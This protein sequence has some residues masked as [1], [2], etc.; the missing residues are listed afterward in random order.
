MGVM[1]WIGILAAVGLGGAGQPTTPAA[2]FRLQDHRGA[3]HTLDEARDRKVVVLAFLGTECP[4]AE[5]Y[6]PRLAGVARDFEARG[7]AFFGIDANPQDGPV[8]IGRFAEKHGLPFPILKDTGGELA[9]R[10]GAERTPEVF[11]LD[12]SRSVAY[13]GRIDDQYAIGVHRPSPTRNDLIDALDALL[14]G[15]PVAAPR[16]EAPGCKIGRAAKPAEDAGVTYAKQVSRILQSHCV[17]CHRPGEI[18]PFSLMDYRQAAGWSSMI[19]EVVDEGRMPPWHASPEHGTFANDARLSADEKKAIREW[20]AAGAPEGNPADLPP[21]PRFVEGWQIPRPDLVLEMPRE[22]EIPAEGSMPYQVVELDPKLT[23]DVWVRASQVRPGNPS[24]V[25]HVVV[26]VLPP[27]VEKIDEA[28]GDFLAAYAPGMPPRILADGVAKRIP[29]G[30]RIALQLHYTPRGTKQVDRSRIG[31][32]FADPA[33]VR[34]EL[35][36]GMALDVRLQIP[37]GTR[38]Y[39]SRAEFRFSRPS[40][41]LSLL[42]HMHLRGRSMTFVAEYP[43]GRREVLLD[44]PR[45][46]FDWQ[47]LYVLDRPKPM[48]EGTIL[49]TEAHFD[50]SAENPNNPDPRRAVTFGE[51][52]WDEM[53]VGYINFTL[54]DQDLTLGMPAAKRLE[55]GRYEVT[56]RHRPAGPAKAVAVVGTF[57]DWKE[58]PLAMAGPDASGAYAA[59]VELAPGAHEYKFLIDGETFRED[60]GNPHSAG[61]FR[62]SVIRLP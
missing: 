17:A 23:R 34:K 53:H 2:G 51:Q 25:H 31:L 30:S 26:Y 45:Y 38:D 24:V 6:A 42:P 14:A 11:V 39:V 20:A 5:A 1:G 41:L 12:G 49:H 27:G 15:R 29:A 10:L 9:D 3:W 50:N 62:N 8:A 56:F 19:A 40:L 58:R 57:T 4:L 52:T 43:D 59:T 18:A 33:T 54:A 37:P 60:P 28:G 22:L 32:V 48:P 16:T 55:S 35:M 47:N 21:P 36:S 44:V 13:R 7:V 61:F 46:E